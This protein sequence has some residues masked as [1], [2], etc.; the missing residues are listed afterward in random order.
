MIYDTI[1]DNKFDVIYCPESVKETMDSFEL[2]MELL[3]ADRMFM[4]ECV[5]SDIVE[6]IYEQ[7]E[8]I[9]EGIITGLIQGLI[10]F[11]KSVFQAI[12]NVL[13]SIKEALFGGGSSGGG[14]S[15]STTSNNN[16]SSVKS[17]PNNAIVFTNINNSTKTQS[18]D[19]SAKTTNNSTKT[20]SSDNDK[21]FKQLQSM[22]T[23]QVYFEYGKRVSFDC[24]YRRIDQIN[25]K[26][27][28]YLYRS[29][30]EDFYFN[31]LYLDYNVMR[32]GKSKNH[33][34]D[35]NENIK[36]IL[37]SVSDKS[38]KEIIEECYET[39]TV[40]KQ[41]D[42][43]TEKR[44]EKESNSSNIMKTIEAEEKI[45]KKNEELC[46]KLIDRIKDDDERNT[47]E[48]KKFI[49]NYGEKYDTS[50]KQRLLYLQKVNKESITKIKEVVSKVST[51][52]PALLKEYAKEEIEYTRK[53]KELVKRFESECLD[54]F[55]KEKKY[56]LSF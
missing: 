37:D 28:G 42:Y 26:L 13:K 55:M 21:Q 2:K 49:S 48:L 33:L 40:F 34:N 3:E 46:L 51:F 44:K 47:E 14:S 35:F 22:S 4:Y 23:E 54:L 11:V 38:P 19:N 9:H 1:L 30:L 8:I 50:E 41:I 15:S 17:K 39:I 29:G 32:T 25:S 16:S 45:S 52:R 10:K 31:S 6:V 36:R 18:S 7:Q 53:R 24:N 12:F 5:G 27:S 20:Q 56:R 43:V